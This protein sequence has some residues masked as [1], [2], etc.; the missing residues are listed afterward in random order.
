MSDETYEPASF[1]NVDLVIE[2]ASPLQ[3]LIEAL[4]DDTLA[5]FHGEIDG[6]WRAVLGGRLFFPSGPEEVIQALIQAIVRLPENARRLWD[7]ASR[8]TF[9]IGIQGG[10]DRR[11]LEAQVGTETLGTLAALGAGI[12]MT[13]YAPER[14][15]E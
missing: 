10:H 14:L 1:L 3:E 12:Q 8:R 4:R 6:R 11:P 15:T 9:D 7:E 5:Q 2:S 13:V